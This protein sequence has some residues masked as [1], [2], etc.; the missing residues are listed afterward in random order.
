MPQYQ[1]WLHHA[2]Y[3][4]SLHDAHWDGDKVDLVSLD[5]GASPRP[6]FVIDVKWSNHAAE[7]PKELRALASFAQRHRLARQPLAKTYFYSGAVTV[8]SVAIKLSPT[9]LHCYTVARNT[10]EYRGTG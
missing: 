5:P 3:I 9:A 6:Q 7:H 4:T 10:L 8:D 2:G 1:Q